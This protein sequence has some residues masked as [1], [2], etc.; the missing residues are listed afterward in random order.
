MNLHPSLGVFQEF[1]HP[2]VYIPLRAE[3][4][5]PAGR[6]NRPTRCD[7][8]GCEKTQTHTKKVLYIIRTQPRISSSHCCVYI[9]TGRCMCYVRSCR[10]ISKS[11]ER[12]WSRA[13]FVCKAPHMWGG[14]QLYTRIHSHAPWGAKICDMHIR[15][16]VKLFSPHKPKTSSNPNPAR[17]RPQSV[18][19]VKSTHSCM[20]KYLCCAVLYRVYHQQ[21]WE[22]RLRTNRFLTCGRWGWKTDCFQCVCACVGVSP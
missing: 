16:A 7:G 3:S 2:K 4:P 5:L 12:R 21:R 8:G 11:I 22:S 18:Y 1:R 6:P 15:S 20:F 14:W 10:N 17:H 9:C 19:R 13:V